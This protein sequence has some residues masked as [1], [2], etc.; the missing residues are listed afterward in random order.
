MPTLPHENDQL[1]LVYT[2]AETDL[3]FNHGVDL[4]GFAAFPLLEDADGRARLAH[5]Y[6]GLMRIAREHGH[7]AI[8]EAPTWMAQ[9]DRAA[10]LGYTSADLSDLNRQAIE[11]LG[12]LRATHA[13]QPCLISANIG[14]RQDAY[15]PGGHPSV[16][17]CR[18]YHGQQLAALAG[19]NLD[20]VSGYTLGSVEEA[21]GLVL[22]ATDIGRPA[23][24][25][26]TLETDGRLPTGMSLGEAVIALDAETDA[27]AAYVMINCS[28]PDHI[29]PA[30]AEAPWMKRVRGIV[31]NA[32]R[33]SHAELDAATKL[34]DGDPDELGRQLAG[35]RRRFPWINVLGGCCGTDMRH[36]GRIAAEAGA[37]PD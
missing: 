7:V 11:F 8:L 22:A 28:H 4:P 21:A 37:S 20:L 16:A 5:G 29:A 23:V 18:D 32:S 31:A 2:G 13:G 25:S 9:I 17:R 19:C 36:I 27:A 15:G 14:P 30:L 24:V 35:F 6:E 26:F 12:D 3:I 34:D 10:P 1:H 33:A